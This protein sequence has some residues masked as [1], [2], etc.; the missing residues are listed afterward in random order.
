MI[1]K[2]HE[3][4][5]PPI[6][7]L[8]NRK[9]SL[10][11]RMP[12]FRHALNERKSWYLPLSITSEHRWRLKSFLITKILKKDIPSQHNQ[13]CFQDAF[14][15]SVVKIQNVGKIPIFHQK[16]P[17]WPN[18]LNSL[19]VMYKITFNWFSCLKTHLNQTKSSIYNK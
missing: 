7:S 16:R 4:L 13:K 6:L 1:C 17:K 14:H 5:S 10:M 18:D 11:T 8:G 15:F 2:T 12:L 3:D 19:N 9:Y